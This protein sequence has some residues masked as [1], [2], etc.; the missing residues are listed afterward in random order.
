MKPGCFYTII[1]LIL[2]SAVIIF[3]AG[4]PRSIGKCTYGEKPPQKGIVTVK[5]VETIREN[6]R[7]L[8]RVRVEG[9]FKRD[10]IFEENEFN[11]C[12]R[13]AGYKTGS[14]VEGSILS[15]GPCPPMYNLDICTGK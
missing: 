9:F 11:N 4:C 8:Y 10:F 2:F 1:Y 12:F 7:I 5:S 13:S 3:F 6:N 14:E 15:G